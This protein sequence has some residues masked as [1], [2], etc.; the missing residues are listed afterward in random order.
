MKIAV[1]GAGVLGR[2]YGAK[3][4]L[5]G[6]RV[7]FVVKPER[8]TESTP[9]VIEQVNGSNNR[10]VIEEPERVAHVPHKTDLVL[11]TV[12]FHELMSAA[13]TLFPEG[14]ESKA[15]LI[16][17][18]PTMPGQRTLLE[19]ACGRPCLCAMP[20]IAGYLGERNAIR[21]WIPAATSTLL[22]EP[23]DPGLRALSETL[24]KKL[25]NAGLPARLENNVEG[26]N[27]ST[28]IAFFPLIAAVAAGG[29]V[30]GVLGDKDL[31]SLAL[32]AAKESEA[33]SQSLGRPAAWTSLLMRFV[34][35]FTLKPAARLAERLF[36]E[37]LIFVDHHFGPK[38]LEQ[39]VAMGD[40]ILQ[41][42]R[43]RNHSMPSLEKLMLILRGK[44]A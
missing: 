13:S 3:L 44:S 42:G 9:F 19:Q 41:L 35:P 33:L 30:F 37:T 5:N 17:L 24:A 29:G 7:C 21:Y 20:G 26:L 43:A 4:L 6:E 27:A 40:T 2:V 15:P 32:A 22:D 25:T 11:V 23:G 39:H 16:L 38:L 18:T 1:L 12:R 10:D 8:L 14:S 36:P 31:F 28:T 34:G